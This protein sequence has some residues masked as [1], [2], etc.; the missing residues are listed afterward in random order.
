MLCP[1]RVTVV[2]LAAGVATVSFAADFSPA[3]VAAE[4]ARANALF[5]RAWQD[6]VDRNP[7]L[8][9][10]LGIKK[11]NDK[12][13]DLSD[14]RALED[15]S[16]ALEF[17]AE[18]KR[19]INFAALDPQTQLS[20]RLF[21]DGIE[22]RVRAFQYRFHNYPVS[23]NGGLHTGVPNLLI[24][25]HR[26]DD[27]NDARAYVARLRAVGPLFAQLIEGLEA[28]RQRGIV[29][30]R[31][32]FPSV[33]ESMRGM[34]SGAPFDDRGRDNTIWANFAR[35]IAALSAADEATKTSL[36]NDGRAA[37]IEIV[38]PAYERLLTAWDEI[39]HAATADDGAWK[40][41]G[42]AAFYQNA[43]ADTTTTE[44]TALEIH[45]IGLR[46]VARLHAD[47][48]AI[49]ARV[50][51]RAAGG[52]TSGDALQAFFRFLRE[53]PQFY[54]PPAPDGRATY[55]SK[56][57]AIIDTMRSRLDELFITKPK[58]A[59][60]VR[61]T[62]AFREK[63]APKAFYERGAPDGSRPGA[64]YVTLFNMR[65]MP[66]YQIEAIAYHEGIPGHHMQISIAQELQGVPAFRRYASYGAYIEGWGL[67]CELLPKEIGL[68]PDP[69]SDFG[70][71]AMELWRAVRLVVDTGIHARRWTRQQAVDY[72]VANT[73]QSEA[74]V[75]REIDRY[76]VNPG[77]ATSYKV[78]M[79]KILELR[80]AAKRELGPKFDLREFHDVVLKDGAVPLNILEENVKAWIARKKS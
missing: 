67:Y 9:A 12:W 52:A 10:Q 73:P 28:R 72:F 77:Q 20:H 46:E 18:L 42:G 75:G 70:R 32:V 56:S 45:D 35:K 74:E 51:F 61:A 63:T 6:T 40:F 54:L 15:L 60:E 59:L 33:R 31:W 13:S 55:L 36:R 38:K 34:I 24:N 22:R 19:T 7:F 57:T 43:L 50:G 25:L 16:R 71:I 47:M 41:P 8:Q 4:S 11:D 29:P 69:Y 27:T 78:G 23:Q 17:L 44:L 66:T 49:I 76:I 39:E 21:A 5:E 58:A 1:L 53:D 48:R 2:T 3:Q 65:E 79:L 62:E 68:Y 64:Y 80:Q 26:V 30:P 14:A 37:L